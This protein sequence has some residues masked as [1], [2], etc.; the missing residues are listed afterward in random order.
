M[1]QGRQVEL[2]FPAFKGKELRI[3]YPE[4]TSLG[5]REDA[6]LSD[7]THTRKSPA[8]RVPAAKYLFYDRLESGRGKPT[9]QG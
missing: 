8:L 2:C 4:P 7:P 3:Y 5:P 6:Q 1:D 9:E